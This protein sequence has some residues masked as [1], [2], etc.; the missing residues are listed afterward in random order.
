MRSGVYQIFNKTNGKRYVGRAKDVVKRWNVHRVH[1]RRGTHHSRYL[2]SSWNKHGEASFEFRKI[3]VCAAKDLL[4]Y[5]QIVLDA[6]VPEYNVARIAGNT[7]GTTRTPETR[8]KISAKAIG[9]K[10]SEEAKEKL[11]ATTTGRKLPQERVRHLIGNKFAAGKKHTPERRAAISA[12]MTGRPRPKS[13]EQ[14]EKIAASLRGR[15]ATPEHRANQSAAQMGK[16]RGPYK[17]WSEETK[18]RF[19][20]LLE[21]RRL[22]SGITS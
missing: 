6:F 18:A 1:L 20:A 4:V 9:R 15:K 21:S 10:W 7:L 12:F 5:E 16:K 13:P 14:R 3:V 8:A 17:P 2:Q 11:R 22:A 19:K